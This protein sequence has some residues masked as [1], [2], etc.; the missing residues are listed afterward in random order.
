[1]TSAMYGIFLQKDCEHIPAV[2]VPSLYLT[3]GEYQDLLSEH[4][5]D[6]DVMEVLPLLDQL[7]ITLQ[8]TVSAD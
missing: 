1:M 3:L 8:P 4:S 6:P 5:S 2:S 7:V